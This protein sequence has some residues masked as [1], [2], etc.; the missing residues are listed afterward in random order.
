MV[1]VITC[2]LFG[3][4]VRTMPKTDD[5]EADTVGDKSLLLGVQISL[6]LFLLSLVSV[7][8]GIPKTWYDKF[9]IGGNC[10]RL[11]WV[12]DKWQVYLGGIFAVMLTLYLLGV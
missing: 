5:S 10:P 8:G 1:G 7:C 12:M 2:I 11:D 4:Y 3:M 9:K 6:C